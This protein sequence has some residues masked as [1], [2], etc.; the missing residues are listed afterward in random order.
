MFGLGPGEILVILIVGLIVLGP[1][2][3]PEAGRSLGRAMVEFRRASGELRTALTEHV[4]D[5]APEAAPGNLAAV[6]AAA[7]GQAQPGRAPTPAAAPVV[8]DA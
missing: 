2:R 3:L 6:L 1:K 5:P 4:I 7:E 8:R